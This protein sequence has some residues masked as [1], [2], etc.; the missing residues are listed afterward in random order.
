MP[1][2]RLDTAALTLEQRCALCG[3]TNTIAVASL[4]LGARR[5]DGTWNPAVIELPACSCGGIE[6]LFRNLDEPYEKNTLTARHGRLVVGLGE[7]LKKSR[8]HDQA[9]DDALATEQ[10]PACAPIFETIDLG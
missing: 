7:H 6:G 9:L 4:R 8:Q 3:K 5:P 10:P 2:Q 1:I